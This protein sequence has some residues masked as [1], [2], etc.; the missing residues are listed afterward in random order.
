MLDLIHSDVRHAVHKIKE[1]LQTS[2]YCRI[3]ETHIESLLQ[4]LISFFVFPYG[5]GKENIVSPGYG[6]QVCTNE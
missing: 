5:L 4:R 1:S 3:T 6:G 2:I